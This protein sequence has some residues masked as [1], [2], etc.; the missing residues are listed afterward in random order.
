[1]TKNLLARAID[2]HVDT[3]DVDYRQRFAFFFIGLGLL[4]S[5]ILVGLYIFRNERRRMLR[6][7][8]LFTS[9]FAI[10]VGCQLFFHY[11][12][13]T[14]VAFEQQKFLAK[15][16]E[17]VPYRD[18]VHIAIDTTPLQLLTNE[19][20]VSIETKTKAKTKEIIHLRLSPEQTEILLSDI[21]PR[22]PITY[23]DNTELFVTNQ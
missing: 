19:L 8:L 6:F 14:N 17:P 10:L 3:F 11:S 7:P 13:T 20:R 12:I 21:P 1:W 23:H 16:M 18:I 22:I 4:F 5:S 2:K 9:L 15:P